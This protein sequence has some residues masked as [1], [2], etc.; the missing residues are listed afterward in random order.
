[1][2]LILMVSSVAKRPALN[3]ALYVEA[4]TVDWYLLRTIIGILSANTITPEIN[5]RV[6]IL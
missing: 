6:T 1:M 3:L 4:L 5:Y 2:Y